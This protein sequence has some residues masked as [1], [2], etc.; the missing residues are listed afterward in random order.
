[1]GFL[2]GLVTLASS[3]T[4]NGG[5]TMTPSPDH[6]TEGSSPH[7]STD[8]PLVRRVVNEYPAGY[9]AQLARPFAPRRRKLF[10]RDPREAGSGGEAERESR[11]GEGRFETSMPV[12]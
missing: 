1:M 3:M 11:V 8:S 12:A 2:A 10:K 5:T 7:R 6:S 4:P 9:V